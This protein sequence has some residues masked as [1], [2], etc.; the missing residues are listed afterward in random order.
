MFL[1]LQSRFRRGFDYLTERYL[2]RKNNTTKKNSTQDLQITEIKTVS[3]IVVM[4]IEGCHVTGVFKETDNKEIYHKL[5][6]TLINSVLKN[7]LVGFD[8][9]F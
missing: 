9:L 6:T 1:R 4:M 7:V 5:K 3:H 8:C 2:M